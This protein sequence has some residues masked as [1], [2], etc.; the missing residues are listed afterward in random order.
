MCVCVGPVAVAPF[1]GG[2]AQRYPHADTVCEFID[3]RCAVPRATLSSREPA[4]APIRA[5][6]A[7]PSSSSLRLASQPRSGLPSFPPGS[8]EIYTGKYFSLLTYGQVESFL[9]RTA[10]YLEPL[11]DRASR[12]LLEPL[13]LGAALATSG[14]DVEAAQRFL[15]ARE[16]VPVGSEGW[17]CR[18]HRSGLQPADAGGV[19]PGGQARV[20]ERR[21]AQGAVGEGGEGGAERCVSQ[22]HAGFGAEWRVWRL[23]GGGPRSAAELME[24]AAHWERS[25][26]LTN[27]PAVKAEDAC[28]ADEC[29]SAAAEC[30]GP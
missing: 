19:R 25:A 22:R 24:A 5:Y 3:A 13:N 12:K 15:E 16:R 28:L 27:A 29:R 23:G 2:C 30:G 10:F 4:T 21:G 14:H 18:G 26:A 7:S 11:V 6:L 8:C 17:A 9:L 20:V 1:S